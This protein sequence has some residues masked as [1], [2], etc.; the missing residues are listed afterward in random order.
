MSNRIYSPPD[1]NDWEEKEGELGMSEIYLYY[2]GK[3][4]ETFT[5]SSSEKALASLNKLVKFEVI[6]NNESDRIVFN[7]KL[8]PNYKFISS[9]NI[10]R[11]GEVLK[12]KKAKQ[13]KD[14][15]YVITRF[16]DL[17]Y[18]LKDLSLQSEQAYRKNS[19]NSS[20]VRK[21]GNFT[22]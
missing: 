22:L 7:A 11:G 4:L 2:N 12:R 20:N 21:G 14:V 9:D 16:Y 1:Q 13:L 17:L 6:I 10:D 3:L 15:N 18:T 19:N 8:D 5:A